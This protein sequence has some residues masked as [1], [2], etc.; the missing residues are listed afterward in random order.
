MASYAAPSASP[1]SSFVV[2]ESSTVAAGGTPASRSCSRFA[3]SR[4]PAYAVDVVI[5][6]ERAMTRFNMA[7]DQCFVYFDLA[8]L[9]SPI[10]LR[11][12]VPK[13][14]VKCIRRGAQF[15]ERFDIMGS[16]CT[17]NV[18]YFTLTH[19]IYHSVLSE[20]SVNAQ[21]TELCSCTSY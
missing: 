21:I 7:K 2:I 8:T 1:P 18:N 20:F 12:V 11:V 5:K 13:P 14:R 6:Q 15:C 9:I 3:C 10:P 19:V 4:D 17:V 16:S